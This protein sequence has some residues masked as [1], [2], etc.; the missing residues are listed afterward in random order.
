MMEEIRNKKALDDALRA[1]LNSVIGEFKARF[2]AE[3]APVQAHA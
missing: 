2:V 3:Q 1:K